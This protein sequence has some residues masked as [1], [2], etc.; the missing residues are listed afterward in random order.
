MRRGV[1]TLIP[2]RNDYEVHTSRSRLNRWLEIRCSSSDVALDPLLSSP[3]QGEG[4]SRPVMQ[5]AQRRIGVRRWGKL[6]PPPE[7]GRLGGVIPG[8]VEKTACV[9]LRARSRGG[10]KPLGR[11]TQTSE[12]RRLALESASDEL[13][14]AGISD[15]SAAANCSSRPA[16]ARRGNARL[17]LCH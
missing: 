14:P 8:V 7:R 17:S 9:N 13:R 11:E 6:P 3:F 12:S 1:P 4:R 5:I 16:S 15:R 10:M 2:P